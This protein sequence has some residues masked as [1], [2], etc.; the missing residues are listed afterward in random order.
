MSIFEK[1]HEKYLLFLGKFFEGY[2]AHGKPVHV[3]PGV[4][5]DLTPNH[6]LYSGLSEEDRL[7]KIRQNLTYVWSD[8]YESHKWERRYYPYIGIRLSPS[9][10]MHEM[11]GCGRGWDLA[12]ARKLAEKSEAR[13]LSPQEYN[14]VL[15]CWNDINKMRL[16]AGDFSLQK[17]LMW[18]YTGKDKEQAD[19]LD[20]HLCHSDGEVIWYS[21]WDD[22]GNVLLALR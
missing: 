22:E 16:L 20:Y 10:V 1:L 2:G 5:I 3:Y 13:F 4:K 18:V 9:L 15:Y 11:I 12:K 19:E 8:G 14:E 7:E 6:D 17:G 21:E